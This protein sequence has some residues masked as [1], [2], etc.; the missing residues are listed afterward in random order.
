MADPR[1]TLPVPTHARPVVV[2]PDD[3][4]PSDPAGSQ[5]VWEG[6]SRAARLALTEVAEAAL[7]YIAVAVLDAVPDA[8]YLTVHL[9]DAGEG[10][11]AEA[12]HTSGELADVPELPDA[13]Y[14]ALDD[15]HEFN[16]DV[17]LPFALDDD[18]LDDAELGGVLAASLEDDDDD[19]DEERFV[20]DLVAVA[21]A[22]T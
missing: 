2:S 21:A 18:E 4:L 1:R 17:W 10:L 16:S 6:A 15:L 5:A 14:D 7:R 11:V 3:Y 13:V 12:L 20:L 19:S 8:V 9:G 22:L